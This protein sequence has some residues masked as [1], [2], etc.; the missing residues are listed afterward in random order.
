MKN[1]KIQAIKL[2][3]LGLA[4]YFQTS[5]TANQLAMY[6]DDLE[7][8]EIEELARAVKFLR[9]DPS[10]KFF[11]RPSAIR[12]IVFGNAKDEALEASNRI[13]EA[14]SRFG[15]TNP[16]RAKEFI[17]ELG[18]RVVE[19]E[20]GWIN[21]CRTVQSYDMLPAFKAQWRELARA[22][23]LRVSSGRDLEPPKLKLESK[24]Q[25]V[26]LAELMPKQKDK[27]G[28]LD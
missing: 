27:D 21:L 11:P 24:N 16:E 17:G 13:V 3:L 23:S 6:A 26:R 28:S 4:E 14:M 9:R 7:D 15:H 8:L 1:E 2:I 22:T 18:W 5:L 25:L 10:N 19:R 12:E 20:G